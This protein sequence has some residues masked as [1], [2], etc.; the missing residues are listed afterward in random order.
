LSG[1][2]EIASGS[3]KG[4]ASFVFPNPDRLQIYNSAPDGTVLHDMIMR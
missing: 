4:P 2:F 1:R 3:D